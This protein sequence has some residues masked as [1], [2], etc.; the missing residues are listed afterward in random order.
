VL[1]AEDVRQRGDVG[2][3][4]VGALLRLFE[5]LGVAEQHEVVRGAREREHLR[6]RH[7]AGLVDEQVVEPAHGVVAR[8]QPRGA[9]DHG[10]GAIAASAPALSSRYSTPGGACSSCLCTSR[11]FTSVLVAALRT[12]ASRLSM[13]LWL[14]A[15]MPTFLPDAT[16]AA[17]A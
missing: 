11:T 6:E 17:I 2:A 1:G 15:V 9:A 12:C 13:T 8:P 7:L 5:L 10:A 3:V 16:S 4:G 14:T